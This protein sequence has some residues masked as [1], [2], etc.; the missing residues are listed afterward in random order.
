MC[1]AV[2]LNTFESL[3]LDNEISVVWSDC[4]KFNEN[5]RG[6]ESE[7][8]RGV[9]PGKLLIQWFGRII[10]KMFFSESESVDH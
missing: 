2:E 5:V 1:H 6:A 3:S 9:S 7:R 10:N 4:L 8:E